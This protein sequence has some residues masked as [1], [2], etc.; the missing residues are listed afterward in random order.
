VRIRNIVLLVF[1]SAAVALVLLL[2]KPK[3]AGAAG[4]AVSGG[5]PSA[6]AGTAGQGPGGGARSGGPGAAGSSAAAGGSPAAAGP[7][8]ARAGR[9]AS[10]TAFSVRTEPVRR[11][12]IQDYI[13]SNGDVVS[14]SA[15]KVYPYIAGR[16]VSL[17]VPLGGRVSKGE[18]LAEVDPSTPGSAFSLNPV[19]A[20][21]SGTVT[22]LPVA[23]GSLVGTGIAVAEIGLIEDVQVEARVPERFV[24]VLRTGLRASV[25]LEAYPDV[26]FPASVVR[27]SPVVDPV[28]RTKTIRL[29][30]DRPDSRVNPGMFARIRLNTLAYPDRLIVGEAALRSDAEGSFVFVVRDGTAS[31]R[32][33]VRGVAVDGRAEVVS[34]LEEGETVVIEGAAALADGAAVRDIGTREGDRP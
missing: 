34:G 11:G 3:A 29:G 12:T 25:S 15:V 19:L 16:L 14:D 6:A 10:T 30:F 22:S 21:I 33:V 4:A 2:P 23:V 7:S 27:V 9:S 8:G 26:T 20:P 31:K 17:K 5:A 13:E 28:S 32:R 24:G 18:V 1:F